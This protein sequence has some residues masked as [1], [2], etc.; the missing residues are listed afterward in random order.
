MVQLHMKNTTNNAGHV[1]R[2]SEKYTT[3][4]L[5]N[6]HRWKYPQVSFSCHGMHQLTSVCA[7]LEHEAAPGCFYSTERA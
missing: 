3:H 4:F 5:H 7:E 6:Q 2:S 1:C